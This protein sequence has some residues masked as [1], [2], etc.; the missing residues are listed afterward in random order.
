M[1]SRALSDPVAICRRTCRTFR[2]SLE[3]YNLFDG[4]QY[5]MG[6]AYVVL[7][8]LGCIL[9]VLCGKKLAGIVK[10]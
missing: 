10:A 8:C 7:S 3:A 1:H 4:K 6:G 9:G 2:K 5:A